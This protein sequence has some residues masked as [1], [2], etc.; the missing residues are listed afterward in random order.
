LIPPAM[1]S[2]RDAGFASFDGPVV[3]LRST[4]GYRLGSRRDHPDRPMSDHFPDVRKM[5]SRSLLV[6]H[7]AGVNRMVPA[8]H[9]ERRHG[10]NAEARE[11]EARIAENVV[12]L[13]EV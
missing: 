10:I 2:L 6:D 13:L 11:L 1:A 8:A 7:F 4:T 5:V 9:S 12:E 3:S